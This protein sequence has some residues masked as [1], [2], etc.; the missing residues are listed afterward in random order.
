M[1]SE[2]HFEGNE[3]K[4][5]KE[6]ILY[7]YYYYYYY[8]YFIIIF[9]NFR[10]KKISLFYKFNYVIHKN[11]QNFPCKKILHEKCNTLT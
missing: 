2:V 3:K 8:Y 4:K 10:K 7:Y 11:I 6:L 9:E 1:C 5:K